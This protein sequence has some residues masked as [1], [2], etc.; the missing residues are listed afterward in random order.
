MICL[1]RP[2]RILDLPFGR[3]EEHPEDLALMKA[4]DGGHELLVVND[5]PTASRLDAER[6]SLTCDVFKLPD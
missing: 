6:R 3:G 2:E 5:G 4:A 1:H